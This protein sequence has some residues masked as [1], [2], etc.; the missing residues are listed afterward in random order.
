M[1]VGPFSEWNGDHLKGAGIV[2]SL[3]SPYGSG[4]C[5]KPRPGCPRLSFHT[6]ASLSPMSSQQPN[7]C[8][9]SA[10]SPVSSPSHPPISS[11]K[12]GL[13]SP[14]AAL[15]P[16]LT[17]GDTGTPGEEFY[18][19]SSKPSSISWLPWLCPWHPWPL[20]TETTNL[21]H[22]GLPHRVDICVWPGSPVL[23]H[24]ASTDTSTTP[25]VSASSSLASP[26]P[27]TPHPS[28]DPA[29][30]PAPLVP[31]A[32]RLCISIALLLLELALGCLLLLF[33]GKCPPLLL[34]PA[35][36]LVFQGLSLAL[37]DSC[38]QG[39]RMLSAQFPQHGPSGAGHSWTD[40]SFKKQGF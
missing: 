30:A 1:S 5:E 28:P 12:D 14:Q 18:D 26:L 36:Q 37:R 4:S 8:L 9:G 35:L 20:I 22:L 6:S 15:P 19:A 31:S 34:G 25:I 13:R 40:W 27:L 24:S 32:T 16:S 39:Q 29:A 3:L 2:L 33:P 21:G 11:P 38:T 23:V 10:L 17:A 7:S